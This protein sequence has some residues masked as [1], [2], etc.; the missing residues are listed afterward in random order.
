MITAKPVMVG[1]SHFS[2]EAWRHISE[3][4]NTA[5][6]MLPSQPELPVGIKFSFFNLRINKQ[7]R[8]SW[9]S[10]KI[11]SIVCELR[12]EDKISAPEQ[13]SVM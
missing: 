7:L 6:R 13:M 2:L 11:C 3:S 10:L 1:K 5:N 12:P 8:N 9:D 4:G